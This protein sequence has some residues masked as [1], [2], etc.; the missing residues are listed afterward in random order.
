MSSAASAD[1]VA[2]VTP[3]PALRDTSAPIRPPGE[4]TSQ[5]LESAPP[6]DQASGVAIPA[7]REKHPVA[8]TLLVL[9]RLTARLLLTGPRYA[10]IEVDE[11]LENRSPN[12]F[13]RDVKAT[14]RFGATFEVEQNLG[15]DVA[16]RVGRAFARETAI[17]G[18]AGYGGA[19][20][21]SG[22]LRA[23]LG[24][25]TA[26]NLRP[27]I[28]FDAGRDMDR[29][30]AGIGA[31]G[32]LVVYDQKM[33]AGGAALGASSGYYSITASGAYDRTYNG[34]SSGKFVVAYN[35]T[36]AGFDE[37]QRATATDLT[38]SY[39]SRRPSHKW[40]AHAAPSTGFLFRTTAGYTTGDATR[41]GSFK[42]KRAG[43]EIRKLID[44]FHGDRVLSFGGQF[45]T[46]DTDSLPFDRLLTIGGRDRL[47]AFTRD[48]FR[49]IRTALIDTMYEWPLTQGSRA[50]VF[51]EIGGAA[52]DAFSTVHMG[53]GGGIRFFT[54]SSTAARLQLAG[55][56]TGDLGFFVQ[57]GAL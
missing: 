57:L 35:P 3:E 55:S 49:G 40:I 42:Y 22:G 8:N 53:Y 5:Q 44:L 34:D 28:T 30:F 11:Y 50:F 21:Q 16:V 24:S 13:G 23:S 10:A 12:A 17:D 1:S 27:V 26:A 52:L 18:Y 25:Y 6:S 54:G 39:D 51:Y 37:T 46:L 48:Q 7:P 45:D 33:L 4:P 9:P 2:T 20:G 14:W 36:L 41:S 43:V 56:D 31:P 19:R 29:A 38:F 47:R 32:A 15:P